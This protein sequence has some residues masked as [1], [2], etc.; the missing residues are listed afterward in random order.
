MQ[1]LSNDS[2]WAHF[3][4]IEEGMTDAGKA[5]SVHHYNLLRMLRDRAKRGG[6][7]NQPIIL[8]RP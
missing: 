8:H 3:A 7:R 6:F 2:L 5:Q 4:V 1:A